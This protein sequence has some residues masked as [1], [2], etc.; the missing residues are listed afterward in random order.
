MKENPFK[1]LESFAME[2]NDEKMGGLFLETIYL[3]P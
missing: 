2:N 1:S 3:I